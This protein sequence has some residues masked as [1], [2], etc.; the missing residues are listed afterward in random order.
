MALSIDETLAG[1]RNSMKSSMSGGTG[2]NSGMAK[3]LVI[4]AGILLVMIFLVRPTIIY[5]EPGHVGIV[6]HRGGGGV[7]DVP[8][9]PGLHVRNPVM[10]SIEEYPTFMQTIVLTR[11]ATEGSLD[12]DEIN[13]NSVEGQPVSVDVSMSFEIDPARVPALYKQFRTD[14]DAIKHGFA[15]GKYGHGGNCFHDGPKEGRGGRIG[16][17][18]VAKAARSVRVERDA[19]HDQR[20]ACARGRDGS[21][22]AQERHAT[23]GAHR[24]E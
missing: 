12:N 7:D 24:A 8:L 2:G 16:A 4:A 3:K 11:S 1:M 5:V 23:A 18:Q 19:I 21:H 20:I 17:G 6:I 10:T 22:L 15:A 13:V 9:G 14:I